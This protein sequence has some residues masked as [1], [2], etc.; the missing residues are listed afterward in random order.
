MR[1]RCKHKSHRG[2]CLRTAPDKFRPSFSNQKS[3]CLYC[4]INVHEDQTRP[5]VKEAEKW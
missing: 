3:L 1:C 5:M 4:Y 2:V